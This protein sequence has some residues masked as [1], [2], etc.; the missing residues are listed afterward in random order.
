MTTVF[1]LPSPQHIRLKGSGGEC[2]RL[3]DFIAAYLDPLPIPEAFIHD[4]KLVSEELL[5][6]IMNHG[7]KKYPDAVIDIALAAD[8][9]GVHMTFTDSGPAFNPLDCEDRMTGDDL[10]EGGMGIMLVK[11]LTDAQTY[12][13]EHDH[14]VF[15]VTKNYNSENNING[16]HDAP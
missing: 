13:R 8:E 11:S 3:Y 10:S 9:Y 7:Y 4:M 15:T 16:D 6:N 2:Q 1:E 5:S 14:N 12:K